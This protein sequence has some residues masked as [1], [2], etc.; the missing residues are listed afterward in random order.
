LLL[1]LCVLTAPAIAANEDYW[2]KVAQALGKEG[3]QQPGQVYRAALPRTD[4]HVTLD[5]VSLKPGFALG[6]WLAFAAMNDN[7]MVMGDLVSDAGRDRAP[8]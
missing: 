4:P 3:S 8:S 7:V 6:G 2:Q 5:G 1:G